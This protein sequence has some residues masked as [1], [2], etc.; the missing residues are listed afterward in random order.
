MSSKQPQLGSLAIQ[1]PSLTPKTVHVSPS[2]CH[3]VSVFK[4]L[5]SQYRK[6]DDTINLRLNRATAQYRD[7]E[8]RGLA[9]KGDVEEQACAQVWRE[10]IANWSR[11]RE[12]VDYCVGVVDQAM[13]E[14]QRSIQDAGDD[15][16]AQRKA[17]GALYAEEVKRNQIRNELFVENIVRKRAFDAFRSRCRYFEPPQTDAEARK[18]W[19]SSV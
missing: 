6:L 15:A 10:L 14:K 7:R 1:A 8:R 3:D 19:E 18:W 5:M 17:R 16:S 13:E 11:R 4:E 2:T 12:L 9:G